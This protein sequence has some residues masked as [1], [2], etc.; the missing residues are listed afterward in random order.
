MESQAKAAEEA[1]APIREGF[2]ADGYDLLVESIFTGVAR[3]KIIAG[4]EACRECL[5]AKPIMTEILQASLSDLPFIT[6]VEVTYP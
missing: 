1:L 2:L 4:P 6:S 5:V 3:I